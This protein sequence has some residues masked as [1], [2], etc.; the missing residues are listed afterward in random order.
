MYSIQVEDDVK[1]QLVE[2]HPKRFKQVVLCIYS[3][4]H[5]PRPPECTILDAEACRISAGPYRILYY[6]DDSARRVHIVAIREQIGS[7]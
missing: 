7:E 3:L 6:V 2:L 4:Q 1:A 5:N